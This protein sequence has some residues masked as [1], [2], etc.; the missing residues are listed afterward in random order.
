MRNTYS[1]LSSEKRQSPPLCGP[2]A[3][4]C[5][6]TYPFG[7]SVKEEVETTRVK[8]FKLESPRPFKVALVRTRDKIE[9]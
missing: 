4:Q 5:S 6:S 1:K 3:S 2:I 9:S 7:S 8:V